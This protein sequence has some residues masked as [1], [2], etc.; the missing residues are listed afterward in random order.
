MKFTRKM[1]AIASVTYVA[2]D[3]VLIAADM[4]DLVRGFFA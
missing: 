2:L 1:T 3:S 4:Y